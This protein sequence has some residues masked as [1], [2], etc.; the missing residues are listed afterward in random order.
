MSLLSAI[1]SPGAMRFI[2]VE[3]GCVTFE[4]FIEFLKRLNSSANHRLLLIVDRGRVHIFQRPGRSSKA[5]M[6]CCGCFIWRLF[7]G[8]QFRRIGSEVSEGRHGWSDGSDKRGRRFQNQSSFI[9]APIPKRSRK[10]SFVLSKAV[11]PLC[12]LNV[13]SRL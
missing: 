11:T 13:M 12:R 7:A 8:T 4:V 6:V 10:H 3:N 9:N 1:T 2:L 5:R